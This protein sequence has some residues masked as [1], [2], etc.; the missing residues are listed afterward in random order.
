MQVGNRLHRQLLH[1]HSVRLVK[2][3]VK[4]R[5]LTQKAVIARCGNLT[6]V[7]HDNSLHP[8]DGGE[9]VGN[10]DQNGTRTVS[11]D[12]FEDHLFGGNIEC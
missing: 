1:G 5:M 3:L 4:R 6:V 8:G 11:C 7:E 9:P 2:S 12:G 10:D